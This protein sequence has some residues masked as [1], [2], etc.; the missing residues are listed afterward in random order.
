MLII[1]FVIQMSRFH[2]GH[3]YLFILHPIVLIHMHDNSSTLFSCISENKLL[4]HKKLAVP[5]LNR[6]F[7]YL[8]L[9]LVGAWSF[10]VNK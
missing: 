5:H 10:I 3:R 2:D 4:V 7:F 8:S 1:F 9:S 6:K